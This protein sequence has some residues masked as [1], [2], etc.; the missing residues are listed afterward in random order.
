MSITTEKTDDHVFKAE[1][2][3]FRDSSPSVIEEASVDV[4]SEWTVAEEKAIRRK[5]DL[6]IT[7]LVTV[8]CRSTTSTESRLPLTHSR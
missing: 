5:F 3:G 2:A 7:P 6:T 4:N 1:P 8:L